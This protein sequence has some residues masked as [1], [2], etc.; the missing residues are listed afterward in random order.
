VRGRQRP[1]L[2]R[3]DRER[4]PEQNAVEGEAAETV[5]PLACGP[6]YAGTL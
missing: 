4:G 6:G 2:D 1:S 5:Q 3:P